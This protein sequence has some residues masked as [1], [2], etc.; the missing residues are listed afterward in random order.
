MRNRNIKTTHTPTLNDASNQEKAISQAL[1][2]ATIRRYNALGVRFFEDGKEKKAIEAFNKALALNPNDAETIRN[3]AVLCFEKGSLEEAEYLLKIAEEAIIAELDNES[4][5]N[6]F[7]NKKKDI[8][9]S[10]Y[11]N[12]GNLYDRQ[13]RY[14]EAVTAYESALHYGRENTTIHNKLAKLIIKT[15]GDNSKAWEHLLKS[16]SINVNDLDANAWMAFTLADNGEVN[17]AIISLLNGIGDFENI[18]RDCE[19]I[20]WLIEYVKVLED[21]KWLVSSLGEFKKSFDFK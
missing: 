19:A 3:L 8:A 2:A 17:E 11:E 7:L 6:K 16:L 18:D 15:S 1:I 4:K 21:K 9:G 13:E 20:N 12:L 10:I 14:V 5:D